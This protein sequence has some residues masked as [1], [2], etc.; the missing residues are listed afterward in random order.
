MEISMNEP[1]PEICRRKDQLDNE[2]SSLI[3]HETA[4]ARWNHSSSLGLM[5]L[6]VG[7]SFAA[8]AVGLLLDSRGKI[9]GGLAI[10]PPLIA[11]IAISLKLDGK[12]SYHY[13]KRD[14]LEALHKSLAGREAEAAA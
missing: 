11:F 7:C 9:A 3:R 5:I 2:L 10:L 4:I 8:A 13:R 6:A 14:A 12:S 1:S